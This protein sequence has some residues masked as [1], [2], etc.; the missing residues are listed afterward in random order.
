MGLPLYVS[1]NGVLIP[2]SQAS[3]PIFNSALYGAFGVYESMQVANG[4]VFEQGAHL[5]RLARSAGILE[6]PLPASLATFERWIAEVLAVNAAPDCTLRLFVVGAENGGE[7]TAFIWPQPALAY[8]A[9]LYAHGAPAITFEGQRFL[10]E[11]KSLNTLVSFLSRRRAHAI[12]AHEALLHHGGAF[13][14]G[15]NSNLFAVIE[16]IVL[17]PPAEAVLSG[18]TRDVLFSLAAENDVA[19]REARLAVRDLPRWDEC[20]ITSST[21]H[22]MP[23]TTIDGRP[24]GDGEVGPL[25]RRLM[26]LFEAYFAQ[27]TAREAS[28]LRR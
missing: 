20:F 18:V 13:T 24:V 8:P 14:E 28:V 19:L 6:L 2:P 9:A 4:V 3:V 11:A 5:V 27:A 17:T 26:A 1:R 23:I 15:S 7:V 21:R 25:T 10:P 12:G 16:G 22:I